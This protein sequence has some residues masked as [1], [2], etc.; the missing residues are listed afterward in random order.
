VNILF[1]CTGNVSRSFFA[2]MLLK[3]GLRKH[4]LENIS[5]SSAGLYAYPGSPADPIIIEYLSDMKIPVEN[6]Q[7]AQ[8]TEKHHMESI[9]S[10]WPESKDKIELLGAYIQ[11]GPFAD[12]IIDPY[13]RSAY[14][15]RIVQSQ[16]SL[17]VEAL[18]NKLA[19][20]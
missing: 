20:E 10:Q 14:H 8:L 9:V 1:V 2:K 19:S 7:S 16:I 15:Y 18:V 6:H 13:G 11:S 17:A 5:V 4:A 3:D 12:D